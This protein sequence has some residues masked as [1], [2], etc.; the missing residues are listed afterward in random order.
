MALLDTRTLGPWAKLLRRSPVFGLA[1]MTVTEA[2]EWR[3]F[4]RPMA[5]PFELLGKRYKQGLVSSGGALAGGLLRG[6]LDRGVDP[7]GVEVLNAGTSYSSTKK[8]LTEAARGGSARVVKLLIDRGARIDDEAVN[9][10]V[11]RLLS[12]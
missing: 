4:S 9:I 12:V 6:L 2:M 8:P 10:A 5:L 1:A 3:V 7:N 11:A